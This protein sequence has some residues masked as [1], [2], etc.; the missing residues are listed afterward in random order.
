MKDR[1]TAGQSHV[2][3]IKLLYALGFAAF[4]RNKAEFTQALDAGLEYE[5]DGEVD[6]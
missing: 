2:D 5:A 6:T 4:L 1:V 3:P